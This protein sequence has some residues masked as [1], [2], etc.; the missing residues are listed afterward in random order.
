M[1][2]CQ[3]SCLKDTARINQ[4]SQAA[5]C[6]ISIKIGFA[7]LTKHSTAITIKMSPMSRII[8]L[9]PVSPMKWTNLV[10]VRR[11]R[12]V[13][14]KTK[15]MI[16][17]RIAFLS[18]VSASSINTIP[19]AIAPGPHNIGIAKGV[20]EMSSAKCIFSSSFNFICV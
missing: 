17:I 5:C 4:E 9:F 19:L 14:R 1:G 3:Y 18:K 16:K 12:A 20:I 15:A 13:I 11:I 10:D 2:Y 6:K 7:P 8:T